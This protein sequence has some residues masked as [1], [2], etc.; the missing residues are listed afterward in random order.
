MTDEI[1]QKEIQVVVKKSDMVDKAIQ[2][3]KIVLTKETQ[4]ETGDVEDDSDLNSTVQFTPRKRRTIQ[5]DR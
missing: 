1:A 2:A 3:K 4:V 5:F